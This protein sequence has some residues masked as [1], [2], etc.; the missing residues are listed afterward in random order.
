MKIC[1][2]IDL[3][4]IERV[5]QA[6]ARHGE[7]FLN[8]V[9]TPT[10]QADCAGRSESLAARY[11]AKEAAAKALSSGLRGFGFTDIEITRAANGAPGLRLH[12]AALSLAQSQGLTVFSVSLTHTSTQAAAV[13]VLAAE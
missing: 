10:E 8:R 9:F 1:S 2:G 13:V 3:I 5:E 4:E 7:R 12:G 6:L 11:A